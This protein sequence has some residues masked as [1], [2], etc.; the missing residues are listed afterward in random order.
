MS[1]RTFAVVI[2]GIAFCGSLSAQEPDCAS[3]AALARMA[4][5]SSTT[6][7]VAEKQNAGEGYK[8]QLVYA[9][10]KLELVPKNKDA[11]LSLLNLMPQNSEQQL[12]LTTLGTSMCDS[13]S[14]RDMTSLA[15]I[16]DRL[17]HDF[18]TAVLLVPQ[19][20]DA[21]V[22]YGSITVGDPHSDFV[23]QMKRVCRIYHGAFVGAVNKLGE[24]TREE[25]TFSSPSSQWF[26]TKIFDPIGCRPLIFPE[27]D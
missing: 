27:A 12:I 14:T 13:E 25:E 8:M 9:A 24:G 21:Y 23:I 15:R 26:R 5:A 10:R 6:S 4:R 22:F 7:L 3:I 11:A 19:K 1:K 17:P 16:E 20:I 2:A 18:A